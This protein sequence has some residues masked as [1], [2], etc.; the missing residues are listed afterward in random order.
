MTG[1]ILRGRP[2]GVHASCRLAADAA[3]VWALVGNFLAPQAW[4]PGI[5]DTR[6]QDDVGGGV[7]R[8]CET[9]FGRFRE[10]LTASGPLWCTYTVLEGPLSVRNYEAALLLMDS[11]DDTCRIVWKSAFDPAPGVSMHI[12]R[13]QLAR[14]YLAGLRALQGRF[15]SDDAAP[16]FEAGGLGEVAIEGFID[17]SRDND[18]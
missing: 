14:V 15:G 8:I 1:D 9:G 5:R 16:L 11:A 17:W 18:N 3:T 7:V 10:Q 4:L 12:A 13:T 2:V 6:K